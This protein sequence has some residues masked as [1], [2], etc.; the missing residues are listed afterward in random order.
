V[1]LERLFSRNIL[2]ESGR[3]KKNKFVGSDGKENVLMMER[4]TEP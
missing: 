2:N 4:A 3:Q 1:S